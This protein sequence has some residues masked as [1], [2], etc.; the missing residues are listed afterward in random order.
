MI[1]KNYTGE[2]LS[3]DLEFPVGYILCSTSNTNPGTFVPGT[4]EYYGQGRTLVGVDANQTE[5][6]TVGK[7]G[8]HKSLQAHSHS[9]NTSSSGGH[10]HTPSCSSAGNHNHSGS[11]NTTG[12]HSHRIKAYT[13][14]NESSSEY[15]L[16]FYQGFGNRVA[17]QSTLNQFTLQNDGS[18]THTFSTGGGASHSHTATANTTGSHS[19]TAT[20]SAYGAGNAQNLQPYIVTYMFKRVS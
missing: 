20:I 4:W 19:H 10:S 17:V 16:S 2:T 18:H 11:T 12:N 1:L 5:F 6:N 15:G 8:G 3:M 13:T 9:G 7:T 14:N